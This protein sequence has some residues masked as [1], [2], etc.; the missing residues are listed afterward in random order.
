MRRR[1]RSVD[2]AKKMIAGR[3]RKA[4]HESENRRDLMNQIETE[5]LDNLLRLVMAGDRAI[6]SAEW[7]MEQTAT[8][9][10]STRGES[11]VNR[12]ASGRAYQVNKRGD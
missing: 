2:K 5:M 6:G 4:K 3:Q 12:E 11:Q 8:A 10:P 1:L 7:Q 9:R